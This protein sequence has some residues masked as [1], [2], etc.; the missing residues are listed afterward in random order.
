[1]AA[2]CTAPLTRVG[3]V[4]PNRTRAVLLSR[5]RVA[6]PVTAIG[7]AS[8]RMERRVRWLRRYHAVSC[9]LAGVRSGCYCRLTVILGIPQRGVRARGML[10]LRLL[11]RWRNVMLVGRSGFCSGW[12]SLDAALAAVE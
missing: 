6:R 7:R 4:R 2:V 1:M 3:A 11:C 5:T 12:L 10:V 8:R 9:E